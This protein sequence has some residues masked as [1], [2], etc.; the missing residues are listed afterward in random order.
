MYCSG[1][2]LYSQSSM[3]SW[4]SLARVFCL[5]FDESLQMLFRLRSIALQHDHVVAPSPQVVILDSLYARFRFNACGEFLGR[6]NMVG[7]CGDVIGY[8]RA[9]TT[10][11][12]YYTLSVVR[13]FASAKHALGNGLHEF[14]FRVGPIR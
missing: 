5:E 1:Q 12:P 3:Q 13:T 2:L 14:N 9:H 7:E 11:L 6:G 8:F 10:S 4:A